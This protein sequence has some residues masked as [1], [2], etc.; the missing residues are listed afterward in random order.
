M[1]GRLKLRTD[2][3][4]GGRWKTL[5]WGNGINHD[6]EKSNL[7]IGVQHAR[8]DFEVILIG[9]ACRV[10]NLYLTPY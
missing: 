5:M 1:K 4:L 3:V 7:E 8:Q 10:V 6:L 2:S 9:C